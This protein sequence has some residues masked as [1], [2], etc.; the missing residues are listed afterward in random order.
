MKYV[1]MRIPDAA[2]FGDTFLEASERA[3]S[4]ALFVK[5][6]FGGKV[7]TVFTFATQ[8]LTRFFPDVFAASFLAAIPFSAAN[9]M[10]F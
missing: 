8:R 4:G 9:Q 2:P 10:T 6:P 3:I 1:S 7:E 5:R